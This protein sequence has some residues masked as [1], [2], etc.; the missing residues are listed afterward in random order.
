MRFLS[1]AFCALA[2]AA[3]DSGG[4]GTDLAFSVTLREDVTTVATGQILLDAVPSVGAT[5][6]G[7]Y[8]LTAPGGGPLPPMT[9]STGN[10][11]G[12][13]DA[14]GVLTL[15]LLEPN[16]NDSNAQLSGV[17]AADAYSGTWGVIT[18]AGYQERGS[19]TGTASD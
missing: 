11:S 13:L 16:V 15:T 9:R 2:L 3:C 5:V 12:V 18:I 10:I 7:A 8:T 6:T 4:P 17:Y 14:S 19:F 1:L